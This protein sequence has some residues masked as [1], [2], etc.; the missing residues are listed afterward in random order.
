VSE[1]ASET[2]P[3]EA[4]PPPAAPANPEGVST[5]APAPAPT[6]FTPEQQAEVNRLLGKAR[7][8][9]RRAAVDE[10]KRKAAEEKAKESGEF[11]ELAESQAKE[12]ADLKGQLADRDRALLVAQVAA[13]HALPPAIADRLAGDDEAALEA[14]ATALAKLLAPRPAPDTE[15]GA[16]T[17]TT[18]HRDRPTPK[19]V[20]GPVYA[21][22]HRPIVPW[23]EGHP[24]GPRTTR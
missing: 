6:A 17:T 15:A 19:K 10:A 22:D 23:P 16:G 14:D 8:D 18:T 11:R 4:T 13:R 3:T 5:P 9:G 21:F 20:D 7:D 12:I 1:H 2:T 24:A